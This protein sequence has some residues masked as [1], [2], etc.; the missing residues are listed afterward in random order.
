MIIGIF[1]GVIVILIGVIF[2]KKGLTKGTMISL[3]IILI[4]ILSG[5]YFLNIF[6]RAFAPPN[7]AIT[8]NYISTDR[9][10]INGVTI[11]KIL[12]DSI[13]DKGYPVKYTTIYTTSCKIQ[14]PKNKPPEPP[15]LI[16]FNKTGKYTWDEDTIKIDYIHKGLSR[17]SLSPKEELWW[18]KKF[19]NN[20]TC[21][22]I[23]E[24]EQ[25]YFFTIGDP[26]V[27]GIFFYID[28]GGKEHQYYL[29][30]G[31]SPI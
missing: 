3:S 6:F 28:K 17:T 10:F 4:L 14:H 7:V 19:G 21:P 31:V 12:V 13:G 16:K 24:P 5:L 9:N 15:S 29:E 23:F 26:K 25:W 27:T 11:E 2:L 8:E 30:S 18:L 20:P 22:L 1:I